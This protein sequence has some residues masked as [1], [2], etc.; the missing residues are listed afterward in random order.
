[1]GEHDRYEPRVVHLTTREP[2]LH[3]EPSPLQ[4]D[5]GGVGQEW[6]GPLYVIHQVVS[7]GWREVL[8]VTG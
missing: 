6:K 8:A 2:S 4:V 7:L 3:D 1:V 5:I